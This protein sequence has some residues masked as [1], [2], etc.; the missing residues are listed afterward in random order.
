MGGMI[1][2]DRVCLGVGWMY[3][4][5]FFNKSQPSLVDEISVEEVYDNRVPFGE[6]L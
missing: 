2:Y 3:C 5:F 6:C 4:L 1:D